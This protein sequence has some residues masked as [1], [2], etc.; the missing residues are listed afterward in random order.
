[1]SVDSGKEVELVERITQFHNSAV[2]GDSDAVNEEARL[3]NNYA[4]LKSVNSQPRWTQTVV[5]NS[6]KN[7]ENVQVYQN[8]PDSNLGEN[9]QRNKARFPLREGGS[10]QALFMCLETMKQF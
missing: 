1:M 2:R 4:Q 9:S 8:D 6:D 7:L 3:E 5:T 10:H